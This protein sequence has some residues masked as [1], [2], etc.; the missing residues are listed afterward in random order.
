[1]GILF[2][3]RTPCLRPRPA[4]DCGVNLGDPDTYPNKTFLMIRHQYP[5]GSFPG[6]YIELQF[7]DE[8][9]A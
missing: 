3:T 4:I 5:S 6:R 2:Q 1:M 9:G 7:M 8:E